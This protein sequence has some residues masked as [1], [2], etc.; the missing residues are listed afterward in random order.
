MEKFLGG[1][2]RFKA[3]LRAKLA[4]GNVLFAAFNLRPAMAFGGIKGTK[5]VKKGQTPLLFTKLQT[6]LGPTL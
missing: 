1:W 4:G 3:A 2:T 6:G 5:F